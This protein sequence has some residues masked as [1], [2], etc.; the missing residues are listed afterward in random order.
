MIPTDHADHLGLTWA[1]KH[2]GP[3]TS[4]L[5]LDLV[6]V[7][8]SKFDAALKRLEAASATAQW[9][10]L[11]YLDIIVDTAVVDGLNPYVDSIMRWAI[12]QAPSLKAF[13]VWGMRPR[14]TTFCLTSVRHLEIH[15]RSVDTDGFEPARQ[16]PMLETLSVGSRDLDKDLVIDELNLAGCLKLTHLALRNVY[17]TKLEKP[18]ACKLSMKLYHESFE[19]LE[20]GFQAPP[21]TDHLALADRVYLESEE[22]AGC[23][24]CEDAAHG[25]LGQCLCLSIK[26]EEVRCL[27]KAD[28]SSDSSPEQADLVLDRGMP[29]NAQPLWKLKVVVIMAQTMTGTIPANLP[30]LEDLFVVCKKGLELSFTDAASTAASLKSLLVLGDPLTLNAPSL[31]RLSRRLDQRGLSLE[32]VSAH[33][34]FPF[35]TGN[36]KG[37]SS[38]IYLRPSSRADE[39]DQELFKGAKKF[40]EGGEVMCRCRAC[41]VCLQRKGRIRPA[42]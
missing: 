27:P 39:T 41:F 2:S 1:A 5:G 7:P 30:S 31:L 38:Y 18:A 28:A 42:W 23:I 19:S 33:E 8:G 10:H 6:E 14:L 17:V 34:K 25:R 35:G 37:N 29:A 16:L 40:L 20:E 11:S 12:E 13:Q 36:L 21:A 32:S 22:E 9:K 3:N 15:A 26:A 4:S 24:L